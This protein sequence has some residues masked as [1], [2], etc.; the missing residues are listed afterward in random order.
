MLFMS[1]TQHLTYSTLGWDG[2]DHAISADRSTRRGE[3]LCDDE[4]RLPVLALWDKGMSMLRCLIHL[5]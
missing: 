4:Y 2:D 1:V 3:L 5:K